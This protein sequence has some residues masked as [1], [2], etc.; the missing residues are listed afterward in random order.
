[1]QNDSEHSVLRHDTPP[2]RAEA[3][4]D[5]NAKLWIALMTA[6]TVV[7]IM[8]MLSVDNTRATPATTSTRGANQQ[9]FE[10]AIAE[11]DREDEREAMESAGTR[12][13][14]PSAE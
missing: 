4:A 11:S 9:R 5:V 10:D 13:T 3:P 6:F 14:Q 1:M 7:G 8:W 2:T 12:P